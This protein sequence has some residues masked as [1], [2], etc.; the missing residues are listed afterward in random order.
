MQDETEHDGLMLSDADLEDPILLQE[1]ISSMI[2]RLV[3][4]HP[5]NPQTSEALLSIIPDLP[6]LLGI[7]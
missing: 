7:I 5:Q 2:K 4:R 6:Q 3:E 1:W